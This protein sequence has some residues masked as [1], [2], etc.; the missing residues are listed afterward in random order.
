MLNDGN[1]IGRKI[2]ICITPSWK[3]GVIRYSE[4]VFVY[5]KDTKNVVSE[6]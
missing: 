2:L 5:R 1:K 6:S 3:R 4:T